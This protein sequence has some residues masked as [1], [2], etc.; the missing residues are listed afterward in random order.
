MK[1]KTKN[2]ILV[3]ISLDYVDDIFHE[4]TEE[5]TTYMNPA[6]PK[7]IEDTISFIN[8]SIQEREQSKLYQ[9]VILL[10][11]SK[12]FLGC[13]G[14]EEIDTTTPELGVWIKKSAHGHGYGLETIKALKEWAE[15]N[16][17]YDYLKYLVIPENYPSRRIPELL[18]G[19]IGNEYDKINLK[20]QKVHL[21]EYRI[22]PQ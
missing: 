8:K 18:G 21:L 5:I 9:M 22:K 6:P 11:E 12:E 4:F 14:I 20:G 2:L 17:S 15:H 16:L 10:K 1:I 7:K 3:E 19:Q 13:C